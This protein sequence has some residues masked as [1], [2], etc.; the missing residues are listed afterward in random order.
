MDV[1]HFKKE[2]LFSVS[3]SLTESNIKELI[4]NLLST[5]DKTRYP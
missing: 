2:D 5:D 1:K 4:D 3:E